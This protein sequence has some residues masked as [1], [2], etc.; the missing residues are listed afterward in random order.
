VEAIIPAILSVSLCCA[1]LFAQN[2]TAVLT[3]RVLDPG[4]LGVA[5]AQI[6]LAEQ[7][8]NVVRSTVSLPGG[9]YR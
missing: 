9:L 8:T 6:Q 3:G 5:N 7:A 4:A 2:E 1:T